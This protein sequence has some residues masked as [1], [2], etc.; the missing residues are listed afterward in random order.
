MST[1][2]AKTASFGRVKTV[3]FSMILGFLFFCT[4]E[5]GLRLWVYLYRAPAERFDMGT[6]T[7]VLVPGAYPRVG[8]PPIKVNSH[9]FVGPEFEEPRA[10]G[11]VRIVTLGYSCTFG[12]G[13]GVETY[14]EQLA[15]R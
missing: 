12:A 5:V 3:V 4:A 14:P 2:T 8:A 1:P 6:G 11:V 7:F 10:P 9:G 13:S 15:I